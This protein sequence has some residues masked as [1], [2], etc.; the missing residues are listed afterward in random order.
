MQQQ[1][2]SF[3]F[4]GESALDLEYAMTLIYPQQA[5]VY[6]VGDIVQGASFNNFLD[7]IDGSYCTF[8]GGDS[9]NPNIDGQCEL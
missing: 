2:K 7:G 1:N 9:K 5:T 6:Q 8:E 4:N 3:S